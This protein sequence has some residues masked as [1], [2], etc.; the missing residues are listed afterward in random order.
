L[1]QTR[2]IENAIEALTSRIDDGPYKEFLAECDEHQ[3]WIWKDPR[4]WITI[5][6]CSSLLDWKRRKVI[7][8]IRSPLRCWVL[9][10]LRRQV[11]SYQS[12]KRYLKL[13]E[14]SILDF[15]DVNR[16]GHLHKTYER[17]IITYP[18]ETIGALNDYLGSS[19]TIEDLR[20]VYR[21]EL[22]KIPRNS[23]I[24]FLKAALIYIRNRSERWDL[25][26]EKKL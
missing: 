16:I 10:T 8:L 9:A 23:P 11:R 22:Y 25:D 17:R 18:D 13:V 19:L 4:L 2:T 15:L 12:L 3:P 20:S 24:D 1:R 5:R 6:F 14:R 21:G 7:V 26:E